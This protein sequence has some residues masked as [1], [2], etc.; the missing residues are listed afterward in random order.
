ML[1]NLSP[2]FPKHAKKGDV[3]VVGK[4]FG[5]SSD[6]AVTS[7][8]IKATGMDVVTTEYALR[9]FYRNCLEIGLPLS[10]CEGIT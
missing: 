8:A 7:K 3:L 1:E 6:R 4:H 5:Q 2:E 9:L 10:E